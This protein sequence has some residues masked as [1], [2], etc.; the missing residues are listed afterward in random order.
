[1]INSILI[2]YANTT[3]Q[4]FFRVNIEDKYYYYYFLLKN[5]LHSNT[6]NTNKIFFSSLKTYITIRIEFFIQSKR[7]ITTNLVLSDNRFY[8]NSN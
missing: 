2:S 8:T 7:R 4:L 6:L 1:M 5:Y 3:C